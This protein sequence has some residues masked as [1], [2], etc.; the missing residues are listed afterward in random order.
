VTAH[1]LNPAIAN[2]PVFFDPDQISVHV[3]AFS[4]GRGRKRARA[5]PP[6]LRAEVRRVIFNLLVMRAVDALNCA[7]PLPYG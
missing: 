4:V 6:G 3:V 5:L 1:E 2:A 7:G